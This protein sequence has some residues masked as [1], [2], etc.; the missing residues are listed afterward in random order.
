[1]TGFDKPTLL[2][3]IRSGVFD[4]D[5]QE[6]YAAIKRRREALVAERVNELEI[7][8]QFLVGPITPK[9]FEGA[10]VELLE[11]KGKNLEV[12]LLEDLGYVPRRGTYYMGDRLTIPRACVGDKI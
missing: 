10:N 4:E 7:G 5:F 12:V 11:F 3:A 2:L 9:A 6:I 8:D 1:M